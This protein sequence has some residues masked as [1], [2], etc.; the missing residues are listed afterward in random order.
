VFKTALEIDQRWVIDFAADRQQYVCQSQS[1]NL[2]F[3]A[4]VSKQELHNT[5]MLAWKK[6]L[7]SLYY[8]RSEAIKRADVVSEQKPREIMLDYNKESTCLSCEG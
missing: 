6:G 3:P 4:N 5:H 1:V 7:K 8:V 2:F